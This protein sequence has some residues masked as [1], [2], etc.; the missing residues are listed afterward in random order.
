MASTQYQDN[1]GRT[2]MHVAAEQVCTQLVMCVATC[3]FTIMI[4]GLYEAS[5]YYKKCSS[6][7][8][9]RL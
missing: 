8:C 4:I 1:R 7:Q 3:V 9:A 2:V 6:N 5:K